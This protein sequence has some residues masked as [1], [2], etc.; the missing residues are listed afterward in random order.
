M[1]PGNQPP[2]CIKSTPRGTQLPRQPADAL[3]LLP[4]PLHLRCRG[5]RWPGC[6]RRLGPDGDWL[7]RT[8]G[9]HV[10]RRLAPGWLSGPPDEQQY[11][12]PGSA[13][14]ALQ[15]LQQ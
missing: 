8:L 2:V 15:P 11:H 9:I 14:G 5:E 6:P 13:R 10:I 4:F 3:P 1:K 7:V 12:G